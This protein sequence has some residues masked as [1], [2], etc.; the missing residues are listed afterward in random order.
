[1]K[2]WTAMNKDRLSDPGGEWLFVT[3]VREGRG[4]LREPTKQH[5]ETQEKHKRL[6]IIHNKL[7][8]LENVPEEA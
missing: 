7:N 6:E 2:F 4:E 5:L 3:W 1:M 8:K